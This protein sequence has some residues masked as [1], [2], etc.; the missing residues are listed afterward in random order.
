MLHQ[1]WRE[2]K[3]QPTM[4][5]GTAVHGCFLVSLHFLCYIQCSH[6]V[7]SMT[8]A[9]KAERERE[10]N[11]LSVAVGR[12]SI[13]F[14]SNCALRRKLQNSVSERVKHMMTNSDKT[15]EEEEEIHIGLQR[16]V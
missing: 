6:S 8:K 14:R 1:K 16:V 15:A 10:S 9:K 11:I 4:L 13:S 7:A 12:S 5:P 3:Q 2:T